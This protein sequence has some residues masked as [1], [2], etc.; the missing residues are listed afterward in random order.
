MLGM[1][2]MTASDFRRYI[3]RWVT[4]HDKTQSGAAQIII[5]GYCVYDTRECIS[6]FEHEDKGVCEKVLQMMLE[7]KDHGLQK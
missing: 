3:V 2:G 7:G 6:L 5:V 4:E 1:N